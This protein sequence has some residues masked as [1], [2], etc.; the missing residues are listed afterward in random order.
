MNAISNFGMNK[1]SALS[2]KQ[3]ILIPRG[4]LMGHSTLDP[5][6]KSYFCEFW[7]RLWN[8]L[9]ETETSSGFRFSMTMA[10]TAKHNYFKIFIFTIFFLHKTVIKKH[11]FWSP[12]CYFCISNIIFFYLQ[13]ILFISIEC[14]G[15]V[16]YWKSC[17]FAKI[18]YFMYWSDSFL[19]YE[20]VFIKKPWNITQ[21]KVFII[22]NFFMKKGCSAQAVYTLRKKCGTAGAGPDAISTGP[23]CCRDLTIV[24][25]VSCA[26]TARLTASLS[27][28]HLAQTK[29]VC[30]AS[31][32][33][34]PQ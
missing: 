16:F 22:G 20:M 21:T 4:G 11:D 8:G 28:P 17:Y 9:S 26:P 1:I 7:I 12:F 15:Q 25:G 5:R 18:L 10:I 19:N 34:D 24:S 14:I 3:S 23:R 30:S 32:T 13:I 31:S 29:S 33:R 27:A 2:V 6:N